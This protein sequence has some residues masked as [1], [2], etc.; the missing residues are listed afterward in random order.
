MGEFIISVNLRSSADDRNY[1]A[2]DDTMKRH[3]YFRNITGT[4]GETYELPAATYRCGVR[5]RT[6][7]VIRDRVLAIA[8]EYDGDCSVLVTK[9][10]GSAWIGLKRVSPMRAT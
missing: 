4:D 8:L 10:A 7:E 1:R 9:S 2:L 6:L 3:S 5:D